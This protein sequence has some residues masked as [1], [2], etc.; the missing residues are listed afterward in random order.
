MYINIKPE[1]IAVGVGVLVA[2]LSFKLFFPRKGSFTH[3]MENAGRQ[4]LTKRKGR[5]EGLERAQSEIVISLLL[6]LPVISGFVTYHLLT[7]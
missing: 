2:L 3:D 5:A 6:L 4:P 1:W 7:R